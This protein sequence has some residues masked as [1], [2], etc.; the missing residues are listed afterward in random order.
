MTPYVPIGDSLVSSPVGLV[1]TRLFRSVANTIF[2][3]T[4][5]YSIHQHKLKPLCTTTPRYRA[6]T[7]EVL[8]HMLKLNA[9]HLGQ[10]IDLHFMIQIFHGMS[11]PDLV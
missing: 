1:L 6:R 5:I 7:R 10:I 8:A 9:A 3:A 4:F 2:T 11:I